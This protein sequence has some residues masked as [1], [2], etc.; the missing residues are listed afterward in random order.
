MNPFKNRPLLFCGLILY[1][2]LLCA[3]LLYIRFPAEQF[4]LFCQTKLEQLLPGTRC[5]I[6][7]LR[8]KFP[9]AMEISTLN[10]HDKQKKSQTLFSLD[11]I[12]IRPELSAFYS[13]FHVTIKAYSEEHDFS[14]FVNRSKQEVTLYDIHLLRLELTK[15]PFL[16]ETFSREISGFLSASGMYTSS[17]NTGKQIITGQGNMFIENGNF[18]LLF[19]ILSLKKIDLE[20]LNTDFVLRKDRIQFT[21]G[22]FRGKELKGVFAGDIT[23]RTPFAHSEFA[24]NGALEPLPPLLKKSTYAQNMVIQLKKRHNRS[25]LPFL[26]QGN[27]QKPRFKFDS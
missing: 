6:G 10:F 12:T 3:A 14:V 21:K 18:S 11:Q 8:Y 27:I 7:E 22:H 13:R 25:T 23:L 17:W 9:V 20:E 15:F 4:K 19:P 16:K 1:T 5:S 24:F 2:L 26:L